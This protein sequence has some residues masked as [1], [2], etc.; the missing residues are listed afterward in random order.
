MKP[1]QSAEYWVNKLALQPHPEGGFYRE[2]YRSAETIPHSGLPPRF[3]DQRSFSTAIYYLLRAQ[4]RSI[5]HRIQSDELWHFYAGDALAVYAIIDGDLT[6]FRL[7]PNPEEG[8]ALQ[9][10]IPANTWFGAKVLSPGAFTLAGC[11]VSPGFDFA[12]FETASRPTLLRQYP[13]LTEVI[14]LLT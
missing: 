3:N 14:T 10:V 5:F 8:D 12:D 7:G 9:I 6:M 1:I 4:D 11:T 2:T 13:Q